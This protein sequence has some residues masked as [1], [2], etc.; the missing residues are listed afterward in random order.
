MKIKYLIEKEKNNMVKYFIPEKI[1]SDIRG[2]IDEYRFNNDYNKAIATFDS[3]NMESE[4]QLVHKVMKL[5]A[6]VTGE[7]YSYE[8]E[9]TAKELLESF[10]NAKDGVIEV[11]KKSEPMLVK[12]IEYCFNQKRFFV[13]NYD[14]NRFADGERVGEGMVANYKMQYLSYEFITRIEDNTDLDNIKKSLDERLAP[15]RPINNFKKLVEESKDKTLTFEGWIGDLKVNAPIENII[16]TDTDITIKIPCGTYNLKKGYN[17]HIHKSNSW[18][19]TEEYEWQYTLC[20]R[21]T[22][23]VGLKNSYINK[24]A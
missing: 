20:G 21:G 3:S 16:I 22:V 11:S 7:I 19:V 10:R 9:S 4:K 6:S 15:I 12:A 13:D 23:T 14:N 17:V 5:K 18:D 8:I 24:S 1:S 2:K